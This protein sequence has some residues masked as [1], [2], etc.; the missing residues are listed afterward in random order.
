[1]LRATVRLLATLSLVWFGFA[2]GCK[3]P[4]DGS[5]LKEGEDAGTEPTPA[6]AP[7]PDAQADSGA[8]VDCACGD[9]E[10]WRK[11]TNDGV[12]DQ[13]SCAKDAI[14]KVV[15]IVGP[16][17][18]IAVNVAEAQD[19]LAAL[20]D[21]DKVAQEI[22]KA[23]NNSQ[24]FPNELSC[25]LDIA[26]AFNLALKPLKELGKTAKMFTDGPSF[27]GAKS[28][29]EMFKAAYDGA[30]AFSSLITNANANCKV[31]PTKKE[32]A[33]YQEKLRTLTTKPKGFIDMFLARSRDLVKSP[34]D[35]I[36]V[37]TTIYS[38]GARIFKGAKTLYKNTQC[39]M[40]DL[41]A[42]E[43]SKKAVARALAYEGS[44]QFNHAKFVGC[45]QCVYSSYKDS[46]ETE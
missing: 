8:A 23:S 10:C 27:E 38:C 6:P 7:G 34:I 33:V 20:S 12:K 21:V 14:E 29:G 5:A 2:A 39:M 45:T 36:N 3:N 40:D 37:A 16:I 9:L 46:T 15:P 44:R 4:I 18:D 1:M 35:K 25:V 22:I 31:N 26:K 43:D 32:W 13:I 17:V 30:S 11:A 24:G 41:K 19:G 28:M 42:L